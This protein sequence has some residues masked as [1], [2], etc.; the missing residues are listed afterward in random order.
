VTPAGWLRDHANDGSVTILIAGKASL[1]RRAELVDLVAGSL[2]WGA[3]VRDVGGRTYRGLVRVSDDGTCYR[4][5]L[6]D[7]QALLQP[8]DLDALL[9]REMLTAPLYPV[10]DEPDETITVPALASGRPLH[11]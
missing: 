8:E 3:E 10:C 9:A 5:D 7:Q 1:V 4:V 2:R 6:V 11:A